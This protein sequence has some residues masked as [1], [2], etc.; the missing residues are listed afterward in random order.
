ML[1]ILV[2]LLLGSCTTQ[3]T[4]V[5]ASTVQIPANAKVDTATFAGGC[6]W[7]VEASFEQIKGVYE[8]VSGYAGGKKST[9]SYKK[10]SA[11]MT[12]HT[13]TVQIY[14]DPEQI[15]YATLVDI[16]FTAHDP[17]QLNRQGPDVGTQYRS[18]V[19]YHSAAQKDIFENKVKEWSGEFNNPIVTRVTP[20]EAFF[21]AEEYHQDY[22][23]RNPFQ[24]YVMSV[25]KPKI[26]RVKAKFS[27][28]VKEEYR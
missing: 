23:R 9:A 1:S 12:Q 14:F 5:E 6:F 19:F 28:I 2:V 8:A 4:P 3:S 20:Y 16:F 22:E 27:A 15:S 11:G 13:E 24:P 18:E 25:S 26:D 21:I 7:C 17:T 10:V